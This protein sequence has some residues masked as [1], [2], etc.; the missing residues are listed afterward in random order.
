MALSLYEQGIPFILSQKEALYRMVC[1]TDNLGIVSEDITPRYCHSFFPKE[2]EIVVFLN[3]WHDE[4]LIKVIE[5]NA[6]WYPLK[7]LYPKNVR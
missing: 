2:D 1:G 5:D 4:E 3:P 6:T 7:Q